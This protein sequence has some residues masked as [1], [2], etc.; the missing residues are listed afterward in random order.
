MA[1][2]LKDSD[3]HVLLIDDPAPDAYRS[4]DDLAGVFYSGGTTGFPKG[5]MLSHTNFPCFIWP[6][7][8]PGAERPAS[9]PTP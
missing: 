1:H 3:T 9:F 7:R 4:G 6:I 2:S 5:V 8:T